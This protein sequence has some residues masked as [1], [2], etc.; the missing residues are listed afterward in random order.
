MTIIWAFC[1]ALGLGLLWAVLK[2]RHL[3]FLAQGPDDYAGG[4]PFDIRTRLAGPM[5]CEGAIFGPTGRV[6]SRFVA[7]FHIRWDGDVGTM[8]EVFRYDSGT[9][10]SRTWHLRLGNAGG[11]V[12]DAA[13]LVGSGHGWQ[14]GSAVQLV[15]SIRLTEAAGGHVLH[16]TDWMYLLEN[17]TIVNRSQFRKFGIKVAELVATIRPRPMA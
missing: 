10:Q 9:V 4:P 2:A 6:V 8:D 12:A 15:Y 17:G 14:R 16:A 7:D 13:D 5:I 3:S 11:I 1:L